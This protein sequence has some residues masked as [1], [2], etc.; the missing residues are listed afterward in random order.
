MF[1]GKHLV[2]ASFLFSSCAHI[3]IYYSDA[4]L[5]IIVSI[6]DFLGLR[7]F[8]KILIIALFLDSVLP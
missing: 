6:T 7:V 2:M 8:A 1:I 3:Y 4:R 5:H